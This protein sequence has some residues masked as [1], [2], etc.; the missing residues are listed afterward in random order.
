MKIVSFDLYEINDI[1]WKK[2]FEGSMKIEFSNR[3]G[4]A[5][6]LEYDP[7]DVA[8]K[9]FGNWYINSLKNQLGLNKIRKN[10]LDKDQNEIVVRQL[11]EKL[12]ILTAEKANYV[13]RMA[14]FGNRLHD[15]LIEIDDINDVLESMKEDDCCECDEWKIFIL[16]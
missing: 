6:L 9:K 12:E 13:R 3:T 11:K 16:D 2:Y 1:F 15:A 14:D 10:M 7:S 4:C 5:P 8:F